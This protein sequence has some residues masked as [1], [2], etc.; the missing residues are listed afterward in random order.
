M[1]IIRKSIFCQLLL[2]IR[3]MAPEIYYRELEKALLYRIRL[4]QANFIAF[5]L[6]DTSGQGLVDE[7]SSIVETRH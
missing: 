6:H 1:S 5:K 7:Y 3:T 4:L 2:K